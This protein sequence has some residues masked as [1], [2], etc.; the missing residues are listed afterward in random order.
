MHQTLLM[1]VVLV[2]VS[3]K[4]AEIHGTVQI[5]QFARAGPQLGTWSISNLAAKRHEC[6]TALRIS[7]LRFSCNPPKVITTADI[8]VEGRLSS[9]SGPQ[10]PLGEI[11]RIRKSCS[12]FGNGWCDQETAKKS[13]I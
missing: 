2:V 7:S 11:F 3:V 13:W 8:S 4:A 9:D 12:P 1:T 6:R 10:V 5:R